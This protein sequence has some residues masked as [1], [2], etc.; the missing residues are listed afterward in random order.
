MFLPDQKFFLREIFLISVSVT[1]GVILAFMVQ[2][3]NGANL[4]LAP[5]STLL[6][7][8]IVS[9]AWAIITIV[10]LYKSQSIY[11]KNEV[12]LKKAVE[13]IT[14]I[15]KK[16]EEGKIAGSGQGNEKKP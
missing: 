9:F 16:Q 1:S 10:I 4:F 15:G 11:E 8:L 12:K 6:I 14:N 7:A 3:L 13:K 2:V 5:F